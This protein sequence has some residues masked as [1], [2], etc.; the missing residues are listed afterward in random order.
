MFS[1]EQH[2]NIVP[3]YWDFDRQIVLSN[4]QATQTKCKLKFKKI[5]KQS[6]WLDY[7]KV[8]SANRVAQ[9]IWLASFLL[10]FQSEALFTNILWIWTCNLFASV[11][12]CSEQSAYQNCNIVGRYCN[13]ARKKTSGLTVSNSFYHLCLLLIDQTVSNFQLFN[14]LSLFTKYLYMF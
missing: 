6:L 8:G 11:A 10:I 2:C 12:N 9:I 14:L 1:C 7:K 3:Q 13:V 4:L 5:F